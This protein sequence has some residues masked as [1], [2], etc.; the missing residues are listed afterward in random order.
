MKKGYSQGLRYLG[1]IDT[2]LGLTLC[3]TQVHSFPSTCKLL[4]IGWLKTTEI[5]SPTILEATR[6][7]WSV[8]RAMLSPR[9]IR[10]ATLASFSLLSADVLYLCNPTPVSHLYMSSAC[11]SLR[12]IIFQSLCKLCFCLHLS[13]VIF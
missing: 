5:Y 6:L 4:H 13:Q 8:R 11:V 1:K 12:L 2:T 9:S 3:E 10:R 7:H